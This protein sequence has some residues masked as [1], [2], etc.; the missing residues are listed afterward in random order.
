MC[1]CQVRPDHVELEPLQQVG[2]LHAACFVDVSRASLVQLRM[3]L[4]EI[5]AAGA[6]FAAVISIKGPSFSCPLP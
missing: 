1:G 2:L 4:L 3:Q 6:A 5:L